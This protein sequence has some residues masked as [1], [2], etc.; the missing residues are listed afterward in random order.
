[1]NRSDGSPRWAARE[2]LVVVVTVVVAVLLT[3]VIRLVA[4]G[5]LAD[6]NNEGFFF[7][8]HRPAPTSDGPVPFIAPLFLCVTMALSRT[9]RMRIA[10]TLLLVGSIANNVVERWGIGQVTTYFRLVPGSRLINV[11][12]VFISLGTLIVFVLLVS[13]L[14]R[15]LRKRAS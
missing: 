14:L 8:Q 13:W 5:Y 6:A 3:Q 7:L 2:P 11:A 15:L 9:R 10:L 4:E 12:D 1:M